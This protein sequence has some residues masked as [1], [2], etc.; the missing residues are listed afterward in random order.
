[1]PLFRKKPQVKSRVVSVV[2]MHRSGTSCLAG[3]L[4][5]KGLYLGKVYE[6][7]DHN[8]KGNRENP[9]IAALNDSILE[10]SGGSWF[11]PPAK[12]SWSRTHE[13]QRDNLISEFES[14][15]VPM[16]GFKEPRALLT[17]AFWQKALPRLKLV[18]TYRHPYL[19]TQSLQRRD[20]MPPDYATRLWETY[21]QKLLV[22]YEQ[23]PFP[24]ISFDLD[25][26]EYL[27][28]VDEI[29]DGLQLP[30]VDNQQA[31]LDR[32]LRNTLS[33][34][35]ADTISKSALA[36]YERLCGLSKTL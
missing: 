13:R 22:L 12:V 17:M 21:N 20:S 2:G 28:R 8:V 11:K 27:N 7:N 24:L 29:A 15:N 35:P 31:F 25:S 6:K 3:S 26:E 16:W 5:Q 4:Q 14:A 30:D 1:M 10:H 32:E 19:V 36:L 34:V 23:R 33:D 9:S 18:G